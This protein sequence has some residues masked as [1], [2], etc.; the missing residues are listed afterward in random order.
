[1]ARSTVAVKFTGDV[2][3]LKR[4]LGDVEGKVGGL[5]SKLAGFGK[6][7]ALGLAG[8][9]AGAGALAKGFVDAAIESQKVT[10]QTGAVIKS[11]GLSSQVAAGQIADLSTKLSLKS[12]VD[13][14]VI[15]S[16]QNM[17]L[18]FANVAKSAGQ[19]GGVFERTSG[20]ALDMSVALG[21]DMSSAS[22]LLGKALNDPVAGLAKLGRSGVQF[23]DDQKKMV[24]AMVAAGDTAGAQGIILD[25]VAKQFGGS[26][27][28]QATAT[29]KLKVAW[30]N[31]Q[32]ELGA[33]L[34]PIL[35]KVAT[36]LAANLPGA[37]AAAGAAIDAVKPIIE[38]V[39][40]GFEVLVL[41]VQEHWPQIQA[42]IQGV[43][44]AV[45]DIITNI[46]AAVTV[47]WSAWGDNIMAF[48]VQMWAAIKQQ[49]EGA[50]GIIRGIIQTVTSLIKG[51][52]S[53]VWD[54]IK[55]IVSGAW[56]LINGIIDEAL[57]K[58]KLVIGLAWDTIK[59]L[60]SGAWDGIK[61]I[62]SVGIDGVVGFVTAL[63]GRIAAV[64]AGAF[65]AIKDAFKSA[66]N[67]VIRSWNGL[68]FKIPG[69]DPPG[70]GPSFGGFTLGVP[71]IPQLRAHGGP[72]RSGD[73]YIVGEQGPEL[74]VPGSS[75]GIIPNNRLGRAGGTTVNLTLNVA[76]SVTSERDLVASLQRGLIEVLRRNPSLELA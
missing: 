38:N 27:A 44:Q 52:W 75:G 42:T 8:A 57:A 35:N 32:E 2:A 76:G 37:M 25:E 7:A 63:P 23:T 53:G 24:A 22:M 51:D 71:N 29:D 40:A 11:M 74:F 66:I 33:K 28:A 18:T 10:A 15:Q 70:P 26:A 14:E 69:F 49:I 3:D 20:L 19:V 12:G 43:M 46:T 39:R 30:G 17:L 60:F 62:V 59:G 4:A 65:D 16:G 72:V 64:A 45:S 34:L 21:T 6:V 61:S 58:A 1:M 48:V 31:I 56:M 50:L 41:W 9:A 5:G 55:E 54:G 47:I 13:D 36:F 68:E 73:P 67:W